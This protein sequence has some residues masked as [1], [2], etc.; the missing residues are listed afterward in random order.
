MKVHRTSWCTAPQQSM[1]FVSVTTHRVAVANL[2]WA[3]DGAGGG[4]LKTGGMK[5]HDTFRRAAPQQG[6]VVNVWAGRRTI[7]GAYLSL[8]P[9]ARGVGPFKPSRMKVHYT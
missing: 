6:M 1:I 2:V 3:R 8:T 7:A 4:G 9:N 5:V